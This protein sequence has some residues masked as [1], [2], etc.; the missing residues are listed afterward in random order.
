MAKRFC[1]A[2]LRVEL[3]SV[4]H[5]IAYHIADAFI[6]CNSRGVEFRCLAQGHYDPGHVSPPTP[7]FPEHPLLAAPRSS[8]VTSLNDLIYYIICAS[9]FCLEYC[10][11]LFSWLCLYW[12]NGMNVLLL[13]ATSL[14]GWGLEVSTSRAVQLCALLKDYVVNKLCL[15]RLK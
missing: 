15:M 4:L 5:Y 6:R 8:C 3:S 1:T 12:F 14:I 2:L 11:A 7:R 13:T 9:I 10:N